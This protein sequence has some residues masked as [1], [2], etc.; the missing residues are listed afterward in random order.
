MWRDVIWSGFNLM[1]AGLLVTACTL[2]PISINARFKKDLPAFWHY[3]VL[4]IIGYWFIDFTSEDG[5]GILTV[6][7]DFATNFILFNFDFSSERMT[8]STID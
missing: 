6:A 8:T 5:L 7:K 2:A 1:T 4:I 3:L